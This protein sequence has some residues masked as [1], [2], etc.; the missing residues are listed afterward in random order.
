MMK[1]RNAISYKK[2]NKKWLPICVGLCAIMLLN[3]CNTDVKQVYQDSENLTLKDVIPKETV[4]LVV[5]DQL[6]A[7]DGI[8]S[9]WFAQVLKDKFNVSLEFVSDADY[10]F[11]TRME[12]GNLG[13]IVVFDDSNT[14]YSVAVENKKLFGF[15]DENL[16][17]NFGPYIEENMKAAIEKNKAISGGTLY[18]IGNNIAT[19]DKALKENTYNWDLR[20]DLYQK[21]GNPQ[22]KNL[23]DLEK[24]LADMKTLE[25]V[26]EN[27]NENYGLSIFDDYDI[28]MS[29]FAASLVEAYY[30][31]DT[32]GFGFY[33]PADGSYYPLLEKDSVYVEA[34]RFYN[35]LYRDGLLNPDSMVMGYDGAV[36]NYKAGNCFFSLFDWLGADLYNTSVNTGNGKALLPVVPEDASIRCENMNIYGDNQIWSIGNNC[37]YPE[38]AMAIINWISTPEGYMTMTYGPKG[39]IWDYDQNGNTYYTDFAYTCMRDGTT[40]MPEGYSGTYTEG[41]SLFNNTTWDINAE[42]PDSNGETYNSSSWSLSADTEEAETSSSIESQWREFSG[43]NSIRTYLTDHYD[44]NCINSTFK[45]KQLSD[46]LV[47]TWNQVADCIKT[48]SWDAIYAKSDEEFNTIIT[49]MITQA[50]AY[51]SDKCMEVLTDEVTLRKAAEEKAIEPETGA[52][53]K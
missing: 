52:I 29:F 3:G 47:I 19:N 33:D 11:E 24:V 20:F 34:L 22:I 42:N 26:G 28:S 25:P 17:H 51:G 45:E 37:Q 46:E 13:D 1:E 43:T 39:I 48:N 2:K 16:L 10:V 6:C 44:T 21:L 27:G 30:G 49:D 23:D 14:D 5:Y 12:L 7:K 32:F 36:S 18:G 40:T 31:Y 41:L 4:T 9:G 15:E 35:K 50:K 8:Q 38:L 53:A